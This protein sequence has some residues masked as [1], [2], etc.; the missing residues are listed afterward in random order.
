MKNIKDNVYKKLT[1]DQRIIASIDA[2][3]RGDNDE[4]LHLSKTCPKYNYTMNDHRF[5]GKLEALQD[6]TV[7]I[8]ND[9]RGCIL[10]FFL[11]GLLEET[12]S[13][14]DLKSLAIKIE[15]FPELVEDLLG[16]RKAW[17]EFLLEE[18]I[19]PEIME[20]AYADLRH[21]LTEW[22]IR[23]GEKLELEPSEYATKTFKKWLR[24]YYDNSV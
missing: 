17:H 16:I 23:I 1:S 13:A 15:L 3:A 7:V 11:D 14:N 12:C 20:F 19:Q 10:A 21:F 9:M 4:K 6:L 5:C 8:E 24:D 22:F 2:M 18:G